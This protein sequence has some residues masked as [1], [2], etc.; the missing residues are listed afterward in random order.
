MLLA[1]VKLFLKCFLAVLGPPQRE[2]ESKRREEGSNEIKT[3]GR[4]NERDLVRKQNG[5]FSGCK[6]NRNGDDQKDIPL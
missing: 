3:E 4:A 5:L 6:M 2:E 1:G